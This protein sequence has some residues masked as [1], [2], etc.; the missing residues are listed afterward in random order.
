MKNGLLSLFT[1]GLFITSCN[2]KRSTDK[3][4]TVTENQLETNSDSVASCSPRILERNTE[5]GISVV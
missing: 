2:N 4:E 1:L 5:N 3:V